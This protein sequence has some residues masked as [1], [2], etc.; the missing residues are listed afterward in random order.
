[1]QRKMASNFNVVAAKF[2]ALLVGGGLIL[3][4]FKGRAPW[5]H[6]QIPRVC[7]VEKMRNLLFGSEP[8]PVH[9]FSCIAH[10]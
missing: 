6:L 5:I 2:F 4:R 9:C 1:M 7:G 8:G 10:A 3:R